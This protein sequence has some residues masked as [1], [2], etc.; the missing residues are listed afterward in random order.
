MAKKT[1]K[2]ETGLADMDS[3]LNMLGLSDSESVAA[4][5]ASLGTKARAKLDKLKGDAA[6]KS[7][8]ASM[9]ALKASSSPA[10]RRLLIGVVPLDLA[11][12]GGMVL[13]RQHT[14]LGLPSAGKSWLCMKIIAAAQQ[15]CGTCLTRLWD[16]TCSCE[17]GPRPMR[18]LYIPLEEQ[19]DPEWGAQN[20]ID[21]DALYLL[22]PTTGEAMWEQMLDLVGSGEIDVVLLDSL[23]V[24][25]TSKELG[26]KVTDGTP[27]VQARMIATG[28]R[29]VLM[30]MLILQ[31]ESIKDP[32]KSCPTLVLINQIRADVGSFGSPETSPGGNLPKFAAATETRVQG[33]MPADGDDGA[34][35]DSIKFVV[36][37]NKTFRPMI[38]GTYSISLV[39]TETKRAGDV[40]D[41]AEI[42]SLAR[43]MEVMVREGV[44]WRIGEHIFR[45]LDDV[46]LHLESHPLFKWEVLQMLV[47]AQRSGKKSVSSQATGAADFND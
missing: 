1:P 47:A 39:D 11:W 46:K 10:L 9:Q 15:T 13:G 7:M 4:P 6:P 5:E 19:Y 41:E 43:D 40:I 21:N 32:T 29:R 31:N 35:L 12:G 14:I 45:V 3:A 16:G 23:A 8:L 27:A 20:G 38:K 36:R 42:I 44:K 34:L 22:P 26:G 28:L 33:Y 18:A 24:L 17:Q 2:T 37:K 30:R 25:T